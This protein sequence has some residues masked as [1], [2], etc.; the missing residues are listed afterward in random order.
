ME[1]VKA[2]PEIAPRTR[3]ILEKRNLG[4]VVERLYG[5]KKKVHHVKSFSF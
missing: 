2:K 5:A 1:E 3:K 4:D